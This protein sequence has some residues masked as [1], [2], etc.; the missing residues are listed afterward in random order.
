MEPLPPPSRGTQ[1]CA[2]AAAAAAELS[3]P[4]RGSG[5]KRGGRGGDREVRRIGAGGEARRRGYAWRLANGK[6]GRAG[7]G[8]KAEVRGIVSDEQA[9]EPIASEEG[10][11][12]F[13]LSQ[14]A[15]GDRKEGKEDLVFYQ[16]RAG[17]RS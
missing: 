9:G 15:D 1:R 11:T 12:L 8:R 2:T 10:G 5:R 17:G 14:S 3:A 4:P 16:P 7:R 13:G 6:G